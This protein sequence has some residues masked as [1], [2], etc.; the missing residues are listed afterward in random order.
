VLVGSDDRASRAPETVPG[1]EVERLDVDPEGDTPADAGGVD[2]DTPAG[3]GDLGPEAQLLSQFGAHLLEFECGPEDVAVADAPVEGSVRVEGIQLAVKDWVI[4]Q[5]DSC[6]SQRRPASGVL[7]S[8][9]TRRA[10]ML[11]SYRRFVPTVWTL[12]G[13]TVV[14]SRWPGAGVTDADDYGTQRP[15]V[16]N[17]SLNEGSATALAERSVHLPS[18]R[19]T[20]RA[21]ISM[22]SSAWSDHRRLYSTST[23]RSLA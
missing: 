22:Y 3:G 14:T 18:H 20:C 12:A 8:P 5:P 1:V 7:V 17:Q 15:V 11:D 16:I 13:T 4:V 21:T 2:R 6:R 19:R 10:S 23:V 9:N